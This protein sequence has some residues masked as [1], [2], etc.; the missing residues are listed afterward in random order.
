MNIGKQ[1]QSMRENA[2]LTQEAVAEKMNVTRQTLSGW[3]RGVNTPDIYALI[4][5]AGVYRVSLDDV[6]IGKSFFRGGPNMK[7][8]YSDAQVAC[9]IQRHYPD[10]RNIQILSGGLVSQ[11][12]AF[13]SGTEK[14]IFQAGGKWEAYEKERYIS[15]QYTGILPV[16][17]VHGVHENDDGRAYCFSDYIKGCKLFDLDPEALV[18]TVPSILDTLDQIASTEIPAELGY[19]RFDQTGRARFATWQA[20]VAAIFN[21]DLYR[22]PQLNPNKADPHI[23]QEALSALHTRMDFVQPRPARLIHGDIGSYNLLASGGQITGAI[24]WSMALYGDPLFEAANILFWNEDKLQPLVKALKARHQTNEQNNEKL[25]CYMLRI[26][27]EEIYNTAALGEIGYDLTWVVN[28]V[29]EV[30]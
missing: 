2:H 28:R 6:F 25:H 16:R 23:V 3:E 18:C 10:A 4:R 11:T 5:L 9:L 26:G 14:Y 1:L 15:D 30:T 7:T 19:G 20:F 13:Q 12:F 8:N 21:E 29:R 22:W 24:D 17:V 27:L